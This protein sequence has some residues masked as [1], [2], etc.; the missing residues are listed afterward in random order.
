MNALGTIQRGWGLRAHLSQHVFLYVTPVMFSVLALLTAANAQ[1]FGDA[2]TSYGAASHTISAGGLPRLGAIAP[3]TDTGSGRNGTVSSTAAD[4]DDTNDGVVAAGGAS[5]D[6]DAFVSLPVLVTTDSSYTLTVPLQTAATAATLAA[7]IDFNRDG[8]F[9]ANEGLVTPLAAGATSA[10]LTF[11]TTNTPGFGS[12]SAGRTYLRLR[13]GN[14]STLT[15]ATPSGAQASGE[16]ED[17]PLLILDAPQSCE[18]TPITLINFNNPVLSSGTALGVGAVYRFPDV[19]PGLDALVRVNAVSGT[20]SALVNIDDN[21]GPGDVRAFQPVVDNSGSPGYADFTITFVLGGSS[22]PY[23]LPKFFAHALDVDGNGGQRKEYAELSGFTSF[24]L[25]NPTNLVTATPA[26]GFAGHFESNTFNFLTGISLTATEHIVRAVYDN[27]STLR[28]RAG[29]TGTATSTATA[30]FQHSLFFQCIEFRSSR[31]VSIA[32]TQRAETSGTFGSAALNV[33]PGGLLQYQLTVTNNGPNAANGATFTDTLPSG[34]TGPSVVSVTPGTGVTGCSASFSGNTLNGSVA[35]AFPAGG[36]CTVVVQATA[37]ATGTFANTATIS[38]P[39]GT[40][41]TN[42]ANNSS[43]VTAAVTADFGDAPDTGTG[44]GVTNYRTML[45]DDGPRHALVSGLSL[46]TAATDADSGALQNAAA[47]AD[48]TT[49]TDDEDGVASF[50][51]VPTTVSQPVSVPVS[52]T[53]STGSAASLVGYLDFNKDG[54]FGDAGETSSTVT[55]VSSASNPRSFD[56]SFTVP[57]NVTAGTTYARFRLGNVASE[58]SASMGAASS[59]EVEDYLVT[60]GEPDLSVAKTS[61]SL[62]RGT[63]GT[64]TITVTNGGTLATNA[65]VT[66]TDVL[67]AGLTFVSATG[68]DW[69]CSYNTTNRTVTCTRP[70]ASPLAAGTSAPPITLTVGVDQGA[71]GTIRNTANVSGGGEVNIGNDAG[72]VDTTF[73]SQADLAVSKTGTASANVGGAVSYTLTV[74]NTGPSN[75]TGATITDPV[76]SA[77]TGVSWTCAATG[78]AS[79]GAASGS[80]NAISLTGNLNAGSGNSLTITVTGTASTGGPITNTAS[81]AAPSG[82]TDPVAGNNSSGQNTI[83]SASADLAITK[84]GPATAVVGQSVSYTL[85]VSNA[86]PSPA[87]GATFSDPVPGNLTGV[88]AV[89]GAASGGAAGCTVNVSGNSVTGSVATLPSGGVQVI[90][91]TGTASTAGTLRN[92]ATLTPPGGTADPAAGNNASFVDTT[93]QTAP[94]LTLVKADTGDF[95]VG[96]TGTY[97]FTVTN[98]G[99]SATGGLVTVTDTLPTGLSFVA[100]SAMGAGWSC[101]ADTVTPQTVTCTSSAA[102]AP[103]GTSTFT[104]NVNVGVGVAVPTVTNTASVVGGG[105]TTSAESNA[106][107]TTVLSPDLTVAKTHIPT[108]FVR[109]STGT[110]TITVRNGGAAPTSAQLSVTDTLPTGLSVPAGTFT[111]GGANG[112]A[113]SCTA[114]GQTVTC[115]STAAIPVT[116]GSNSSTFSLPVSVAVNVA[117]SVTNEARVSGGNE[118]TANVTPYSAATPSNTA[119]DVTPTVDA[120]SLTL[121]KTVRNVTAGELPEEADDNGTGKPDD[122]LEYCIGYTNPGQSDVTNV[123]L[124]DLAPTNTTAQLAV[125]DYGGDAIKWTIKVPTVSADFL[126]AATADDAG[127]LGAVLSVRL[128][129]VPPTGAGEVCFQ[130]TID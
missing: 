56:V 48:D 94:N 107:Q 74:T 55:V 118:A 98:T 73:T 32:K 45:S 25:D 8:A 78:T 9:A 66:V 91:V 11:N 67:P 47:N 20:S 39:T 119:R 23:A 18:G 13:I 86:G 116:A 54:D 61:S 52:V 76:P 99:G 87:G 104:F 59:G 97:S 33:A 79:C 69:T 7:W 31:D 105:D 3:D 92:T 103:S 19:I 70:A 17:H 1:D 41:D 4:E 127:E 110:Y 93:V 24:R 109:G 37:P 64:Y 16:V 124:T 50:P 101:S 62:V 65:V 35:T 100:G 28:Y 57:A 89:C 106:D 22:T 83:I 123:L 26:A 51:I 12:R 120:G 63:N 42:T 113:W 14:G 82:T 125:P 90:T 129:T 121:S 10:V 75:V 40:T 53:N 27:T 126:S 60:V 95:T 21:S 34:L 128:G 36:S 2:P 71:S 38:P 30:N 6:E 49:G 29:S 77:V 85:T 44:T 80:G 81:V 84:T 112:A 114:S 130:V 5:D 15:T 96:G 68:T 72:F 117:P 111:P 88:T 43:T 58:V 46:G 102:I 122:V 108:S 115:T